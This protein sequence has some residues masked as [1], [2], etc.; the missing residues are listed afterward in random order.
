ME[1]KMNEINSE[2]SSFDLI[3]KPCFGIG[4]SSPLQYSCLGN[5]MDS[6]ACGLQSM[7]L[8]RV[9]NDLATRQHLLHLTLKGYSYKRVDY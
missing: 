8:Q 9:R 2:K 6:G 7:G 1:M 4:N 5:P 3:E